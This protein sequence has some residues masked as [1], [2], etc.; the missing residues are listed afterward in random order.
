MG[1][2]G[3]LPLFHR[4]STFPPV[5]GCTPHCATLFYGASGAR[6]RADTGKGALPIFLYSPISVRFPYFFQKRLY[7]RRRRPDEYLLSSSR[8][9]H[10]NAQIRS[11]L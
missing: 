7:P 8:G 5:M 3:T 2:L 4:P 10:R 11:E 9:Q 1:F 6:L